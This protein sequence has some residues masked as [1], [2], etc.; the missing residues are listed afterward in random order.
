MEE[1]SEFESQ[2]RER[3][4]RV[5]TA[6]GTPV[7]FTFHVRFLRSATTGQCSRESTSTASIARGLVPTNGNDP[8]SPRLQLGA[9][10]SQLHRR[11]HRPSP[12]DGLPSTQCGI[13]E[14]RASH[15]PDAGL[16]AFESGLVALLRWEAPWIWHPLKESNF[17]K[18]RSKRRHRVHRRGSGTVSRSRTCTVFLRRENSDPSVTVSGS[19]GGSRTRTLHLFT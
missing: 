9:N 14:S 3:S 12:Q 19:A 13:L 17:H 5:A 1:G 15:P 8:L 16:P 6:S 7:R 10:P 4:G 11:C 2:P 18:Q